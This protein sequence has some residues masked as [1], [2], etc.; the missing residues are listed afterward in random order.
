[1]NTTL[2]DIGWGFWLRWVLA[3][4]LGSA[5][6]VVIGGSA[7]SAI[8]EGFAGMGTVGV[9][10]G[11]LLG[12]MQWLVMR[13]YVALTGW[14]ALAT[15]FGYF[16]AGIATE[17]WVFRQVPYS[18]VAVPAIVSF[19]AVGG[20][21]GGIMQWLILRQHVAR[22]GW[23]V[24]VSLVGLALGIGIGGPVALTLGQTGRG[25]ESAIVFGVL[26]AVGV[27]AIPGAML[28]WLL[29]QDRAHNT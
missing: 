17:Q 1:M 6:G 15:A 18:Q 14:W 23:W 29:G 8:G 24:V 2:K 25:V 10:F 9:I 28:V 13:K 26:F 4:F 27:G 19:G 22:S 11:A 12:T 21:V 3:S 7:G 16:L 20:I 5:A